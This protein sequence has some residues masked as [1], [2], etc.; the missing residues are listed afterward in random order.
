MRDSERRVDEDCATGGFPEAARVPVSHGLKLFWG[1]P[2]QFLPTTV[3]VLPPPEHQEEAG[4]PHA[5]L[6]WLFVSWEDVRAPRGS[7]CGAS[8]STVTPVPTKAAPRSSLFSHTSLSSSCVP[9]VSN[10]LTSCRRCSS[11]RP[12]LRSSL[13]SRSLLRSIPAVDGRHPRSTTSLLVSHPLPLELCCAESRDK[14]DG[15]LVFNPNNITANV[16]DQVIARP[17]FLPRSTVPS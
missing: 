1:T 9:F 2:H 7:T 14:G 11:P 3:E 10:E 12:S 17:P 15:A 16:G 4:E 13:L 5:R 6:I 8:C